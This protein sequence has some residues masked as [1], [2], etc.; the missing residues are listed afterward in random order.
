MKLKIW[1]CLGH[2]IF[3]FQ[4]GAYAVGRVCVMNW[5]IFESCVFANNAIQECD[6]VLAVI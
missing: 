1:K 4:G 6:H 5:Y 3:S 2:N